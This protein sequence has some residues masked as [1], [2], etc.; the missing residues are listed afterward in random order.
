MFHSVPVPVQEASRGEW[1][2]ARTLMG[3]ATATVMRGSNLLSLR[4]ATL[5]PVLCGTTASGER[6]GYIQGHN[7]HELSSV[8]PP[9]CLTNSVKASAD[10]TLTIVFHLLYPTVYSDV[11]WRKEDTLGGLSKAQWTEAQRLQ[12]WHPGQAAEH[13][14]VQ[15]A[16]LPGLCLLAPPTMEAGT[17]VLIHFTLTLY[18]P[19]WG[20][21]CE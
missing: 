2:S 5:G 21:H 10:W 20:C 11:W 19:Q 7:L 15:P 12:L 17:I 1:W 4:A 6:W 9:F 3:A 8:C 13:G 16:A 14:A 18:L